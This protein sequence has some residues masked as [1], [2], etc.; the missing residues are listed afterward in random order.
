MS[1]ESTLYSTLSGA[2]GVT[3]LVSTRIY[4][5]VVP[6][7]ATLPCVAFA[8]LDTAYENTIHSAAPILE[9]AT[10]EISCMATTRVGADA[11]CDAVLAAVGAAQFIPV[12]RRAEFDFDNQMYATVL[13]VDYLASL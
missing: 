3:A 1:V 13:S 10:M 5:D 9:T 7:E 6:Q 2:A 4:P 11:L 12:G 8:R